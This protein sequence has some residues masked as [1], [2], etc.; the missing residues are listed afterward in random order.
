MAYAIVTLLPALRGGE[1]VLPGL[2]GTAEL[3]AEVE[4]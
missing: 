3:E 1:S 4:L 2:P